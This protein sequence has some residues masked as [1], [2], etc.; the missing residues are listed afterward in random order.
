MDLEVYGPA[1]RHQHSLEDLCETL[2][3]GCARCTLTLGSSTVEAQAPLRVVVGGLKAPG[4]MLALDTGAILVSESGTGVHDSRITAFDTDGNRLT[5]IEG[6]P[7]GLAFPNN[8]PSGASGLALRNHTLYIAISAGDSG[9]AGPVQG[10]EI[11]NPN[12]TSPIYSS[13]SP[14]SSTAPCRV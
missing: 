9:I 11:P 14:S 7:S 3:R 5:L 10:S 2:V 12:K 8:D 13:S 4:K 6:L 1:T